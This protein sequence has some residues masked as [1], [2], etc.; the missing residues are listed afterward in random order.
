MIRTLMTGAITAAAVALSGCGVG[1]AVK[2]GAM[3]AAKWVFTT[4][5]KT[6]NIDLVSRASLNPNDA[7]QPLSTI[8]R[9]YQLKS[10]QTFRQ[11]DYAQLQT[12]DLDALKAD[13]L[14]T[15]SVLL[16]P[17]AS[18]SIAE[19]MHVDAQFVGV[20]AFFRNPEAGAAWKLLI[21]KKQWKSTD[22]VRIDAY[23]NAL[24]L[25]GRTE[26]PKR[27]TAQQSVPNAAKPK[28]VVEETRTQAG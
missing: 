6:M 16:R 7:S 4:Q 2:D 19:P 26:G 24:N 9:I 18:V 22:P 21:P 23:D 12:N 14:V 17:D 25:V 15:K 5:V 20:V 13:L 28:P 1:Q 11:L 10:G 8:V 3:D 27:S